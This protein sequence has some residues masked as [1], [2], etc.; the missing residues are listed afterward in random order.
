MKEDRYGNGMLNRPWKTGFKG[1]CWNDRTMWRENPG[2]TWWDKAEEKSVWDSSR[3]FLTPATIS[4]YQL[5]IRA[6]LAQKT[7]A[8]LLTGKNWTYWHN[9]CS[10]EQYVCNLHE[11]V[12]IYLRIHIYVYMQKFTFV[13]VIIVFYISVNWV[14]TYESRMNIHIVTK[15]NETPFYISINFEFKLFCLVANLNDI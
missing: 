12:H 2:N 5:K 8:S 14:N 9:R 11:S 4:M 13:C 10:I 15:A 7:H 1:W 3:N 6:A